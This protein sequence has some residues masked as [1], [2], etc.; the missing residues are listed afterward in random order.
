MWDFSSLFSLSALKNSGFTKTLQQKASTCLFFFLAV[1][2][3]HQHV[4]RINVTAHPAP[5]CTH[6][7]LCEISERR[8]WSS[9]LSCT[10][11]A[12]RWLLSCASVQTLKMAP[13]CFLCAVTVRAPNWKSNVCSWISLL[14]NHL[15]AA[16][17]FARVLEWVI[18]LIVS[19]SQCSSSHTRVRS[20]N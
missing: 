6:K 13:I 10:D 12:C 18:T 20:V 2:L 9:C 4:W 11:G 7:N 17:L 15:T 8:A 14:S 16:D 3:R 19:Q 1:E 5:L